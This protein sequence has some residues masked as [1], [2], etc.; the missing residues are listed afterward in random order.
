MPS[1]HAFKQKWWHRLLKVLIYGST[2]ILALFIAGLVYGD[3]SWKHYQYTYSFE[4]NYANASGVEENCRFITYTTSYLS[5]TIDCGEYWSS[6]DFLNKFTSARGTLDQ[7]NESRKT[8]NLTDEQLMAGA[9]KLGKFYG[10]TVKK[11]T[12]VLYGDLL[13]NIFWL[14]VVVFAWFV[15]WQSIV[16]R[17]ILYV[18][19]GRAATN[20]NP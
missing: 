14:L 15:F 12:I 6:T 3:S 13:Q 5:P 10:I 9:I 7:L 4:A 17:I 11:E 20:S 8:G 19:Y 18:I 2:I 16:Y 1:E